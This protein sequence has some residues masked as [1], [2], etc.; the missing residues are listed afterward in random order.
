VFRAHYVQSGKGASNGII[1]G[2]PESGGDVGGAVFTIQSDEDY[3][4]D[5]GKEF[6]GEK[7]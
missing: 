4:A 3:F 1:T 5:T 2:R 7:Q 6:V